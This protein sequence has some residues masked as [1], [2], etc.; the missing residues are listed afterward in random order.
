VRPIVEAKAE[1]CETENETINFVV[2]AILHGLDDLACLAIGGH[3]LEKIES[4]E[5]EKL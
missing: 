2:E 5:S 3:K 1:Y 4:D